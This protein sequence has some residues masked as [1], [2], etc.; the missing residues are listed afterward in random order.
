MES[1][2]TR[3]SESDINTD[4]SQE[5]EIDGHNSKCHHSIA[6]L[7]QPLGHVKLLSFIFRLESKL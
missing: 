2:V 3:E 1:P 4:K 6:L 7:A 5:S